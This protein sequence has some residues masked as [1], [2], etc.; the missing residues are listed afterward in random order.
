MRA[1]V[2]ACRTC[3][4]IAEQIIRKI[5]LLAAVIR[6]Y[7]F[8]IRVQ[9]YKQQFSVFRSGNLH[10]LA[11]NFAFHAYVVRAFDFYRKLRGGNFRFRHQHNRFV[12]LRLVRKRVQIFGTFHRRSIHRGVDFLRSIFKRIADCLTYNRG[13]HHTVTLVQSRRI[14]S[15][16]RSKCRFAVDFN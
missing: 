15:D 2:N 6:A 3:A 7:F 8:R 5:V 1:V 16:I 11:V 4:R 13:Q 14:G 9:I 10:R 12:C